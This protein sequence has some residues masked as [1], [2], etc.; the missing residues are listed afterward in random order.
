MLC[1]GCPKNGYYGKD[2]NITCPQNCQD[3]RCNIKNG[4]CLGCSVGYKG[5]KC[6]QGYIFIYYRHDFGCITFFLPPSN[7]STEIY[8]EFGEMFNNDFFLIS[9]ILNSSTFYYNDFVDFYLHYTPRGRP[10]YR[11]RPFGFSACR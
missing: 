3:N 7:N 4:T 10:G 11:N 5:Q 8:R 1:L 9:L 6:E 2:C